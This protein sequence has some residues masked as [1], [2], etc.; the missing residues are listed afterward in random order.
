MEFSEPVTII[1][2]T[3][4]KQAQVPR[5]WKE[6]DVI[7]VPKTTPV[8][9]IFSD[10]PPISLTA[11]LSK[12]IES[13]Q[14]RRIMDTIH[15]TL[16]Q[17]QFGSLKGC[18]TVDALISMFHCWFSDTD[19]N[20]ATVRV[21]LL[22]FSKAFDRINHQILIKKMRL[23]G[24][25]NSL[26][27]WVIDF[28]MQRRQRVKLGSVSSDWEFVNGGVPQGTFLGPLLFLIIVNDLAVTLNNR[29]KY[30]DNTSLSETIIKGKQSHL[31]TIID[32]I[33][34]WCTE[35]DMVLNHAK[36]KELIISFAKDTPNFRP[37]FVGEHCISR[38]S[39]AKILGLIFS[40]DLHWNL[41]IEYIVAKASKRLCGVPII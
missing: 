34:K 8:T 29:W 6:A 31:Q 3:S 27:N 19:G 40:S 1:F 30:V 28:L 21:F 12:I 33:E 7:P 35:N 22:D 41:H 18:S 14:F 5:Q 13:F 24:I 36:C 9:D 4:I 26:I 11:T 10:L 25:D 17:R 16:D 20:G 15:S 39:S 23:L 37:L 38:V 32:D 2:N